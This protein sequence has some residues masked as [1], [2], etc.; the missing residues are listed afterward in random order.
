MPKRPKRRLHEAK[1]GVEGAVRTG[2]AGAGRT[3]Y[4]DPLGRA[5]FFRRSRLGADGKMLRGAIAKASHA[6]RLEARRLAAL[7]G[8]LAAPVAP[9]GPGSINWTSLGPEWIEGGQ[10]GAVHSYVS[11]RVTGIAVG[12]GG[13]RAY[14]GTAN[15]GVW[16]TGD[17]GSSWTA[18]DE[19]A[20][21]PAGGA[22][23]ISSTLETDSLAVGAVAVRFGSARANDVVF[24]GTGEPGAGNDGYYGI[25]IKFSSDG[26]ATFSLEA[27]NLAGQEIYRVAIDPEDPTVVFAATT[28]GLYQRPTAA[29]Y[30]TW[31]Q[32]TG[33]LHY[34]AGWACDVVIAGRGAS[35]VYYVAFDPHTQV[36]QNVYR[37]T[38]YSS[39][40][41]VTWTAL[42]GLNSSGRVALAAGENDP[43]VVYAL[44]A[45]G[46]L[47]RMDSGTGGSLQQVAGVPRALF[48]G[49]QGSYDIVVAAD[50][51]NANTVYLAGDLTWDTDDWGLSFYKGTISGGAGGYRFPFNPANDASSAGDA[52]STWNVPKD[53]TWIGRG[54]HP[55]AHA[56][57]FA[58]K[59]DGTHDPSIVW[60]GSDGGIFASTSGGAVGSFSS[61]NEGINITQMTYL[62]QRPDTPDILY[63]GCQDNG[64]IQFSVGSSKSWVEVMEGDGG[65]VAIDPND[66]QQVIRQYVQAELS[67]YDGTQWCPAGL[68]VKTDCGGDKQPCVESLRS[69]FYGPIKALAEGTKTVVA[70]GTNR[71]WFR[72]DWTDPWQSLPSNSSADVLDDPTPTVVPTDDQPTIVPVTAIAIASG[73]RVYAATSQ[74]PAAGVGQVWH[75]EYANGSWTKQALPALPNIVPAARFFTALSVE[76]AAAGTFY[77]TLGSG[78]G[79]HVLY[80]DGTKWVNAGFSATQVDVPTHAV[81]VDPGRA[82]VVY[83]GTDVGVWK[84]TRTGASWAW[85]EFSQGLPEAAVTDLAVHAGARRLRAAT[86]GRG[87]WE[88]RI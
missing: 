56:L 81:A 4:D 19:Y 65:G 73:T 71:L 30:T 12:P 63:G 40:D 17:G 69:G 10:T 77:V 20:V 34:A 27:T 54:V 41:G 6:K 22:G 60:V 48:A 86:H 51:G 38:V 13:T 47:Y 64:T 37:S 23:G 24:V 39:K 26:G 9:G 85:T 21:T 1:A 83:V 57:A 59:A 74:V 33:G 61:K 76:D 7:R 35:K 45:D 88:I 62:A 53:P 5:H 75:F 18:L 14:V 66:P 2:A 15:G 84:G 70:Y 68:P 78:G 46:T 25:G 28:A 31:N 43:S 11:G 72:T 87:V 44:V 82:G 8:V 79:E 36:S 55:D 80:F 67:V 50:P 16:F 42:P 49:Q 29:P 32:V 58:T 3:K 52:A